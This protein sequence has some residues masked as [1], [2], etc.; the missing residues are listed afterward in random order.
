VKPGNLPGLFGPSYFTAP[1][2]VLNAKPTKPGHFSNCPPIGQAGRA[3]SQGRGHRA[4]LVPRGEGIGQAGRAG[5]QGRGHRAGLVPRGEGI[6]QGWFPGARASGRPA[7]LV[8]RG[9]GI[10]QAGRA[11][12]Q[13]RGH[14]AGR[15]GRPPDRP[16]GINRYRPA[17]VAVLFYVYQPK[18]KRPKRYNTNRH[19]S[20]AYNIKYKE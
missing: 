19:A 10:G 11:G 17:G 16:N 14:R 6:G 12:S 13:G 7:G 3:G 20:P 15:Q 1:D 5:S 4:G 18:K 2:A 8:P 9:E